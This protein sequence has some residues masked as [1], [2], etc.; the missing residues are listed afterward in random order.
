M[1]SS[2]SKEPFSAADSSILDYSIAEVLQRM[3]A[4]AGEDAKGSCLRL[5]FRA[6]RDG[7]GVDTEK[8]SGV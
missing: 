1:S 7:F 8:H 6:S 3:F 4:S 5:L 2:F